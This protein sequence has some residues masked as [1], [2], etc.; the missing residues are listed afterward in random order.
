MQPDDGTSRDPLIQPLRFWVEYEYQ[1]DGSHKE[2]EMV[3]WQ[4]RGTQNQETNME[5]IA[6]LK[7]LSPS[8]KPC[9]EWRILEPFYDSWKK[10]QEMP[11]DG[12][13]LG[14]WPHATQDLIGAL[15]RYNIK[16]VEGIAELEDHAIGRIQFP[17]F[18]KIVDMAR[19]FLKNKQDA[20]GVIEE[21]LQ[22]DAVIGVLKTEVS[23]LTSEIEQMKAMM[24]ALQKG[25]A[26]P[27]AAPKRFLDEPDGDYVEFPADVEPTDV[28][29]KR[30]GRPPKAKVS[31]G[32]V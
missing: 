22:K 23:D 30:R 21:L 32:A 12:T 1:K 17:G 3:E 7:K 5:K 11:V 13:P 14:A 29:P 8:G 6:R 24:A 20:A 4:R 31:D 16:T 28:A 9:P 25:M 10:G 19:A 27:S 15:A 2:H 18:R 26:A